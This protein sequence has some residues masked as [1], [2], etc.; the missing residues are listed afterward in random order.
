MK[1]A[2]ED[3]SDEAPVRGWPHWLVLNAWEQLLH[4]E[5]RKYTPWND[6]Q[7]CHFIN[8]L[9]MLVTATMW[10]LPGNTLHIKRNQDNAFTQ[11]RELKCG[12]VQRS[13]KVFMLRKLIW[14]DSSYV[15]RVKTVHRYQCW[16]RDASMSS[17]GAKRCWP[18]VSR[19]KAASFF[20]LS[21]GI[22]DSSG[23]G[24]K[25]YTPILVHKRKFK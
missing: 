13:S 19:K 6:L 4:P 23:Q 1:S 16:G 12:N 18:T 9:H 3:F 22:S 8:K 2:L 20:Q 25:K 11:S 10:L 21:P 15:H 5:Q 14:Y 7:L 24:V 17:C